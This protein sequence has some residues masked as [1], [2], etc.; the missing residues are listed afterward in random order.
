MQRK[1]FLTIIAV[2]VLL[3]AIMPIAC[4]SPVRHAGARG[5][6]SST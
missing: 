6:T 4:G 1:Y 5:S 2:L 3:V